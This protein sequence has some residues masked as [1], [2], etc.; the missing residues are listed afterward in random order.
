MLRYAMLAQLPQAL[1]AHM[2]HKCFATIRQ[3]SQGPIFGIKG[4]ELCASEGA[5]KH[6][7]ASMAQCVT[8]NPE[9]FVRTGAA[10]GGYAQTVPMEEFNL[11]LTGKQLLFLCVTSSYKQESTL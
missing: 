10:G 1:G 7:Q 9:C 6:I 3:P 2:G 11:H 4:G 8:L 5:D